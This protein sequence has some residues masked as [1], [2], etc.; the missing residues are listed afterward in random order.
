MME[1]SGNLRD[2]GRPDRTFCWADRIIEFKVAA[3]LDC[4]VGRHRQKARRQ[5]DSY[6]GASS[7]P[8]TGVR[9]AGHLVTMPHAGRLAYGLSVALR[10]R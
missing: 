10:F 3:R 5:A 6:C 1:S 2:H 7:A 4:P 9:F 8:L